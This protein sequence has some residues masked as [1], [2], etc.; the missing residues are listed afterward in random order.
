MDKHGSVVSVS[1]TGF[2]LLLAG[3]LPPML[4]QVSATVSAS[5]CFFLAVG[6]QTTTS[7]CFPWGVQLEI[8]GVVSAP[9]KRVTT[10]FW[11]LRRRSSSQIAC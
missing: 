4:F 9:R 7:V 6:F 5:V 10:I 3:M 1:S 8:L 2:W 11:V